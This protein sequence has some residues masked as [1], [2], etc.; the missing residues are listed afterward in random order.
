MRLVRYLDQPAETADPSEKRPASLR[1]P[2]L[3]V[4]SAYKSEAKLKV[5]LDAG[6]QVW[7]SINKHITVPFEAEPIKVRWMPLLVRVAALLAVTILMALFFF[8]SGAQKPELLAGSASEK[9][10]LTLDNGTQVILRPNS[11]LF[12]VKKDAEEQHYELHG[13]GFFNVPENQSVT[14]SIFA[15]DAVVTVMG[16]R[17]SVGTWDKHTKIY[18]Q[19]GS[20]LVALQD[21]S[22]PIMLSQGET[23]LVE[24][25]S[26]QLV[27]ENG[28]RE[29]LGWLSDELVLDRR[30]L[31]S[32]AREI[33]HHFNISVHISPDLQER[34]LSGT[35]TLDNPEHVLHDLAVSAGAVLEEPE[36]GYFQLRQMES[37]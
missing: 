37:N 11:Q 22:Q 7:E 19:K 25:N 26:I 17:F 21:G 16:T 10:E 18:L 23:A 30:P 15:R 20:V 34:E 13:E 12:L 9:R 32:I 2:L 31:S 33:S 14:F 3:P 24:H 5:D 4:L 27:Q 29:S 6:D 36:P 8:F 1:D 35:L 28:S